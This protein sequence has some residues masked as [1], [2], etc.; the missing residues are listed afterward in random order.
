MK[1]F[2]MLIMV[3]VLAISMLAG[4]SASSLNV[5]GSN[6]SI[7]IEAKNA[8]TKSAGTTSLTVGENQSVVFDASALTKGKLQVTLKDGQGSEAAVVSVSAQDKASASVDPGEYSAEVT[9][10][11]TADGNAKIST[12]VK[13]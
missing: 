11:E 13:K 3:S 12:E 2:V 10:L 6:T 4:C 8:G 7:S 5:V 1:K 9:V